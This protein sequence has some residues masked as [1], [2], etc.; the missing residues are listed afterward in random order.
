M[1]RDRRRRRSR[2]RVVAPLASAD[3]WDGLMTAALGRGKLFAF[4]HVG[5]PD[6]DCG[7]FLFGTDTSNWANWPDGPPDHLWDLTTKEAA[8]AAA[9][10]K[11][12]L[13][14]AVTCLS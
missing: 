10:T 5:E 3:Y 7:V 13:L 6:H 2:C 14:I 12:V 11:D 8:A 9:G 1:R 4:A